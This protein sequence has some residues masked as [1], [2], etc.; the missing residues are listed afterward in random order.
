MSSAVG[1]DLGSSRTVIGAVVRG[2]VEI[3]TN[4]ASYRET[5][6]YVGYGKAERLLGD[7]A[8]SKFAKNYKNTAS[9]FTRVLGIDFNSPEF[10][11]EK[12]HIFAKM[13]K[14]EK[15]MACYKVKHHGQDLLL[16]PI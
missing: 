5:K 1:I 3:I 14:G 9:F 10:R 8:A 16:N 7:Q 4:E 11:K 2:G 15:D 12:K 13:V 6:N